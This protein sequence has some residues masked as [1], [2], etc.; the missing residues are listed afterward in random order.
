MSYNDYEDTR[1]VF[2]YVEIGTS[3]FEI[4]SGQI[5][6]D[7]TYILVEPLKMYLDNIPGGDNVIKV[8]NAV[9][10]KEEDLIIYYV[11]QENIKKYNLPYWVRG[12][13]KIGE[14][15]PVVVDYLSNANITEDIF[16]EEIVKVITF[17][18]LVETYNIKHI[19][20]LKIDT[21]GFDHIIFND[22]VNCIL[23]GK[24]TADKITVEYIEYHGNTHH[25]DSL[26][27][28][29]SHMFPV[30]KQFGD[31]ITFIKPRKH[32]KI[33]FYIHNGWVFGKIHNELIK[34]IFPDVYADILCW[35]VAYSRNEFEYLKEKYD[36]FVSTPDGC[37]TLNSS[38]GIPLE[39]T[40]AI[41]HQDY[42]IYNPLR[43][44]K[45]TDHFNQLGGYA[46]IAP[47]LQN[48]SLSHGIERIPNILRI[49]IFQNNYPKNTSKT[50]SSIGSFAR[51][52]RSDQGY[53]V[54]RGY[55]IDKVKDKTDL[56]IVKNE[57]IN[58]LGVEHLY[59]N[60][61]IVISP[62]LVEGNPYPMLEAFACG[63]PVLC[64][65][66]GIAPDYIIYG[67]GK[68]LPFNSD[69]FIKEAVKEIELMKND[70]A[71]YKSRCE[72][73]FAIGSM[74]DWSQIKY[75]WINFFNNL[76]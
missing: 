1:N 55:L 43:N 8:N 76:S 28:K 37:F 18:Q 47:I 59:K 21:E 25:I 27:E 56:L 35:S 46:V 52:H 70:P 75:E 51:H 31:N 6:N 72:E 42:D 61:N 62:S 63:I 3:D 66:T 14:K 33:L 2:D 19:K 44:G 9:G 69:D 10:S 24:I 39:K 23:E 60:I 34:V 54:K 40:V 74:I 20:N 29:I 49:G 5:E 11:N 67:G 50:L 71:Y 4:G 38:F 17:P 26:Y 30:K 48:I 68:L 73:S 45:T 7:K 15:H 22:I 36:Y 32:K 16:S 12:C 41:V 65:P 13:N 57:G 58:F 53:D 64:T